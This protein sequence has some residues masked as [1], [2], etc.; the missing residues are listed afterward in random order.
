MRDGFGAIGSGY[1]WQDMLN[2]PELYTYDHGYVDDKPKK[3][4]RSR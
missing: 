2:Y 3:R 4:E 1:E